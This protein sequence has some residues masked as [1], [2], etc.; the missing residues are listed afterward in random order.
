MHYARLS[1]SALRGN[2]RMTM[3]KKYNWD[4]QDYAKHSSAQ[5]TW[6]RELILKLDLAGNED[7]LDLGCGDGKVTAEIAAC[8]P[9]GS[10]VGVDNSGS[11]IELA[12]TK[13]PN[14]EYPNLAFRLADVRELPFD[15][16]FD[17][18]FSNAALHWVRDHRPVLDGVRRSLRPG[19]RTLLQMG[20]QG[21]AASMLA[22]VDAMKEDGVWKPYFEGFEF[23]YGFHDPTGYGSRLE[24]TGLHASRVELIP[25]DMKHEGKSDLAAWIRTTWLPYTDRIPER[26]REKFIDELVDSYMLNYPPDSEGRIHVQMVRLE[27]EATR[28]V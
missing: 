17:I 24:E 1:S 23:P 20:G 11:M 26:Q 4:A 8:V 25:K 19:G 6:A 27:V 13:H 10:V 7:V 21:N 22:V 16:Q 9:N 3:D 14:S 18:V 28:N 12:Q 5:Q 2:Q 15:K